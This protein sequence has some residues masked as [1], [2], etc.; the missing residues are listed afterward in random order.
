MS[1]KSVQNCLQIK[2][3]K[4]IKFNFKIL[5]SYENGVKFLNKQGL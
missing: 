4:P 5:I 2:L 1:V 3:K